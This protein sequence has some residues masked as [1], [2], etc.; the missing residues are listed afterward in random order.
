M[1]LI[2]FLKKHKNNI[3]IQN[4]QRETRNALTSS[5]FLTNI[6]EEDKEYITKL[7]MGIRKILDVADSSELNSTSFSEATAEGVFSV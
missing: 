4:V 7:W 6:R 5:Q 3:K 2:N 1:E